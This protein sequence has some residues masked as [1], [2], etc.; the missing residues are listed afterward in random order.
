MRATRL[1]DT[2]TPEPA[3]RATRLYKQGSNIFSNINH[4]ASA[5]TASGAPSHARVSRMAQSLLASIG[6]EDDFVTALT[7]GLSHHHEGQEIA[8][9]AHR[10]DDHFHG[11]ILAG[12]RDGT[13]DHRKNH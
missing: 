7:K 2:Q 5:F 12:G 3:H 8:Q 4:M 11:G 1:L 9:R 10:C 13:N 6:R